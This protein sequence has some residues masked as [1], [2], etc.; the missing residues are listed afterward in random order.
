VAVSVGGKGDQVSVK[1]SELVN[2]VDRSF[3]YP[4]GK[5]VVDSEIEEAAVTI[6]YKCID[7]KCN[8]EK[9]LQEITKCGELKGMGV[10]DLTKEVVTVLDQNENVFPSP[11]LGGYIFQSTGRSY[12]FL[13]NDQ[14]N[15]PNCRYGFI[16]LSDIKKKLIFEKMRQQEASMNT[17][18][19]I[20]GAAVGVTCLQFVRFLA[21]YIK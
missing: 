7:N 18:K 9:V 5:S 16:D 3:V 12:L 8:F 15:G 21:K 20:V 13:Q 1:K 14:V 10:T 17:E 4:K 6:P 11:S 2:F 19:Y